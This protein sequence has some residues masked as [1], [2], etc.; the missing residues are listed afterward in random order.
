[1]RKK[2]IQDYMTAINDGVL[3]VYDPMMP[4]HP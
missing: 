2:A 1:M 4:A 3:G